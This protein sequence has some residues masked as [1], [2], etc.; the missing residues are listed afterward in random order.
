MSKD[1]RAVE[2]ALGH[3]MTTFLRRNGF[4][5][6]S[7]KSKPA[8]TTPSVEEAREDAGVAPNRMGISTATATRS[9]NNGA[10]DPNLEVYAVPV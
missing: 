8:S 2:E 1:T 6:T 5:A 10:R 7:S 9:R 4:S 3:V